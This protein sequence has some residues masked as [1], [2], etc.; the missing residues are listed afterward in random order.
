MEWWK[1]ANRQEKSLR[2]F[3]KASRCCTFTQI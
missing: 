1:I 3:S 2:G